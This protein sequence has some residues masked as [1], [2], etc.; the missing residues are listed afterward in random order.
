MRR[1]IIIAIILFLV[2]GVTCGII[3]LNKVYLPTKIKNQL[4]KGLEDSLGY[5]VEIS[6]VKYSIFEG[7][8]IE[9]IS[10]YDKVKDKANTVLEVPRTSFNFLLL[11]ILKEKKV[12]IPGIHI[13][14]P[15]LYIRY[16]TDN[17][18]NLSRISAH[19]PKQ[20]ETGKSGYSFL[21]YKITISKASV[22]FEDEHFNPRITRAIKDLDI[23]LGISKF[24][25][26]AFSAKGNITGG[27]GP[28][29]KLALKGDYNFL[30]KEL[31]AKL[32]LAN[33][34]IPDLNPYLF[35]LPLYI[36][37]GT[38]TNA[39]LGIKFKD[40]IAGLNGSMDIKELIMHQDKTIFKGDINISPNLNYSLEKK[41]L[42]YKIRLNLLKDNLS[43]IPYVDKLNNVSG[44][45][46]IA[47]DRLW[48]DNLNLQV[49]DANLAIKGALDNFKAP[50]L[51][52]EVSIPE[53]KLENITPLFPAFEKN[54][55]ISG[56][57]KAHINMDGN[58]KAPGLNMKA[59]LDVA[60]AKLENTA[61]KEPVSDIKGT[62]NLTS[63]TAYSKGLTFNYR[64]TAYNLDA[65]V[66]DF[67]APRVN[68]TLTSKDMNLESD[69]K[70][71]DKLVSINKLNGKYIDSAFD[72]T[73]DLDI[74]D[75]TNPLF[76][77]STKIKVNSK[78]ILVFL[79][80]KTSDSLDKVK[81]EAEL[82]IAGTLQGRA[83]DYK[84]WE[85]NLENSKGNF[86]L[87]NL[88]FS[89]LYF[90]LSQKDGLLSISQFS[91][92]GYSGILKAGFAANLNAATPP[93]T[94]KL[95]LSALDLAKLKP[96]LKI[97]E[98]IAGILEIRV[99]STGN[100]KGTEQIKGRGY[101][102]VKDGRLWKLNLFKGIGELLFLPVYEKIVFSQATADFDI[103]DNFIQTDNLKLTSDMMALDCKGK[104]GFNGELDFTVYTQ[105]NKELIRDSSDMRKFA[106]AV[107]GQLG[108]ALTIRITGTIQK[109]SYK[110]IPVAMDIIKSIK[111]FI[112]SK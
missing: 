78:D 73:G 54:I 109:P 47:P 85:I 3:Y 23:N 45:I 108:S 5:N 106:T 111:D 7:I 90:I 88:K 30:A 107:L 43:G 10:V 26:I 34:A 81:L 58:I 48:T 112:S 11:P 22:I 98:D 32:N 74:N 40:K 65:G 105:V 51:K 52:V 25:K 68:L 12:I 77:L 80:Q 93:Y 50:Y 82:N 89:D 84:K 102:T 33:L 31:N 67:Q 53:V 42:D 76:N 92:S 19:P 91:A 46:D 14:S 66:I 110:V 64:G 97:K 100:F 44:Y 21:V 29:S 83:K 69:I 27:K 99:D 103:Q 75:S 9:N 70:I 61:L 16:Q 8:I 101:L 4:I 36:P 57:A 15:S 17:Q 1:N 60:N 86:S 28:V 96:D 18:F 104:L 41:S 35:L 79:P 37:S 13:K 72:I 56:N 95:E 49:L 71:K 24:T 62:I 20:G 39:D 87:Y 94:V 63:S 38:I 6:R 55:T 59:R 2:A